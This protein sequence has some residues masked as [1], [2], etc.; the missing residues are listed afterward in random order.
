MW[1]F[2]P[3]LFDKDYAQRALRAGLRDAVA[4]GTPHL[5]ALH[6]CATPHLA[7]RG[8]ANF[9]QVRTGE[10]FEVPR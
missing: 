6:E 5:V 2:L 7:K 3:Q 4:R 8:L 9:I 1:M 10:R